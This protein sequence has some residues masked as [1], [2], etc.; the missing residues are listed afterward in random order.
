MLYK[1][2]TEIKNRSIY[3][4]MKVSD[5]MISAHALIVAH[6]VPKGLLTIYDLSECIMNS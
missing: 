3:I 6:L 2:E 4:Y 1:D 5:I